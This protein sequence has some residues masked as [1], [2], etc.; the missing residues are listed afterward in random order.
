MLVAIPAPVIHIILTGSFLHN[1]LLL[2]R[3][4]LAL[5]GQVQHVAHIGGGSHGD[6]GGFS[7]SAAQVGNADKNR[8]EEPSRKIA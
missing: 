7:S 2:M 4:G 1:F 6:F 5:G 8:R 3:S